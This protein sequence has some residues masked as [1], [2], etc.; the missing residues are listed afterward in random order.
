MGKPCGLNQ[1][2]PTKSGGD[3]WKPIVKVYK[4]SK[5]RNPKIIILG[6][7]QALADAP[8][9]TMIMFL[10]LA[11][12]TIATALLSKSALANPVS[13]KTTISPDFPISPKTLTRDNLTA[14]PEISKNPKSL[15]SLGLAARQEFPASLVI[16]PLQNCLE[17]SA[18]DLSALPFNECLVSSELFVS[19]AI[20]QPSGEGLP[21][22][23]LVGPSTC[24][25]F[26]QIPAVNECFNIGEVFADIAL[27]S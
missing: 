14:H 11:F 1:T 19:V 24:S 23:V 18:I 6:G 9:L 21:F 10:N 3:Q 22:E 16:C 27:V 20:E 25:D 7:K 2:L 5:A 17:C 15:S 26:L 8:A 13:R 4:C 12:V